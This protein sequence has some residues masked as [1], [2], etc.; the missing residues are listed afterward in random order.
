MYVIRVAP[1]Q[2][3]DRIDDN[4]GTVQRS[5]QLV[6]GQRQDGCLNR[7]IAQRGA[8]GFCKMP[9]KATDDK[10]AAAKIGCQ[11]VTD[12]AIGTQYRDHRHQKSTGFAIIR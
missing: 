1:L 4:I 7:R 5:S 10:A 9:R 6:I 12:Q 2:Y 3:T 8:L 11:R